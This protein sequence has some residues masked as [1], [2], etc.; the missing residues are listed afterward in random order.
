MTEAK[1]ELCEYN[2]NTLMLWD[3]VEK[4]SYIADDKTLYLYSEQYKH[5][6]MPVT[7]EENWFESSKKLIDCFKS[8]NIPL[9]IAY[10]SEKYANYILETFP[11]KFIKEPVRNL[12]DYVYLA[13][14]L[15]TLKGRK[16]E[17]KRNHV[18][19][20]HRTF[21]NR[22]EYRALTEADFDDCRKLIQLWQFDKT[23][24]EA[25]K[26]S[27]FKSHSLEDG[28]EN[29]LENYKKLEYK[30]GGIYIDNVLEAFSIGSLLNENTAQIHVEKANPH[31][32]G[33][34]QVL[35][36]IFLTENFPD[37]KFVN[38]EDDVGVEGLRKA[39][40]SYHPDHMVPKYIISEI[41]GD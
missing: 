4:Y 29:L 30:I 15:R 7:Q 13:E 17:K 41:T 40:L 16:F 37:V 8:K 20:F 28:I 36:K 39:K 9:I 27:Y 10:S 25:G 22:F 35:N 12:Y 5:M 38:R 34:Y 6:F 14:E 31:I 18:N 33:L 23:A 2:F 3:P 11:N 24:T 26:H 1:Y 21:E 19:K 32:R